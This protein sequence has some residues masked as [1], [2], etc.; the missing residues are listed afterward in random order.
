VTLEALL[1]QVAADWIALVPATRPEARY[2]ALEGGEALAEP[3]LGALVS[4]LHAD[5]G[6][7]FEVASRV[8]IEEAGET[9]TRCMYQVTAT[10]VLGV[11]QVGR[12]D[13]RTVAT[14]EIARLARAVEYR[15]S[16]PAGVLEVL[17]GEAGVQA[18]DDEAGL[19]AAT[20]AMMCFVEEDD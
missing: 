3:E 14:Q 13:V 19:A 6:F 15:T 17:T 18:I 12:A 9:L 8:P 20:L 11:L 1:D 4:D 5:R 16:W 7:F 2:H 10:L